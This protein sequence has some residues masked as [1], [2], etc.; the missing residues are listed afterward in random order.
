M[1]KWRLLRPTKRP[2][3]RSKSWTAKQL[4]SDTPILTCDLTLLPFSAI[5]VQERSVSL[6]PRRRLVSIERAWYVCHFSLLTWLVTTS[7]LTC[8]CPHPIADRQS[9]K[10]RRHREVCLPFLAVYTVCQPQLTTPWFT[11]SLLGGE[12]MRGRFR[13]I[14]D[15]SSLQ[16]TS[17]ITSDKHQQSETTKT[18]WDA[19]SSYLAPPIGGPS[20]TTMGKSCFWGTSNGDS[21]G[22]VGP[23]SNAVVVIL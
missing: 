5:V 7:C 12:R 1:A 20:E 18:S 11:C 16:S 13:K 2:I 9:K 19:S 14:M 8:F 17:A 23:T 22:I 4:S 10:Q 6:R 21:A 15:M 3:E